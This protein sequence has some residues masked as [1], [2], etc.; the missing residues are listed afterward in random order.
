MEIQEEYYLKILQLLLIVRAVIQI[1][2][3]L[4]QMVQMKSKYVNVQILLKC[5]YQMDFM[6]ILVKTK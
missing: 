1:W 6:V 2:N 5:M 4:M 3:G